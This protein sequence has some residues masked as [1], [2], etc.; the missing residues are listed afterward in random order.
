MIHTYNQDKAIR[1]GNGEETMK[2][3]NFYVRDEIH[4]GL[5]RDGGI[6]DLT[7]AG[8][9]ANMNAWIKKPVPASEI[10]ELPVMGTGD[11]R[12]ACVTEP[13]KIVCVG[14]NYKKHAEE[15]GGTA[16]KEP[17]IFS[18]FNDALSP[19]GGSIVLPP[20]QRCYDY[21]AELVIV[22]GKEAYHVSTE[23]ALTYVFGYT[24][25]NDLSA[26][27]SQFI[28]NQWLIG[29]TFPGFAPCGPYVVTSDSFNPDL[30]HAVVLKR[31]GIIVQSGN[32]NDMI[33]SCAE[34]VSYASRFCRLNP[35]DLIFTGTPAGV[36]MGKEKGTRDW[37]RAGETLSILIEGIGTLDNTLI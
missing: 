37:L 23:D 19:A 25:G 16:P 3:C 33:F 30:S 26:R 1:A 2:L 17:V 13:T 36:I 7:G 6:S 14:L 24:C 5:C 12:F 8:L 32:T 10:P 35:G 15:T 22:M 29:K 21:E 20:W 28:S 31:N 34:I 27:D 4:L 18:K 9:A 11:L